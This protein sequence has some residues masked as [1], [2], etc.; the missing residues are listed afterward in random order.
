MVGG[1]G[2]GDCRVGTVVIRVT[3]AYPNHFQDFGCELCL[4][5]YIFGWPTD[6]ESACD[7]TAPLGRFLPHI[8]EV[9]LVCQSKDN[10]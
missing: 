5:Y 1:H 9:T 4:C 3:V 6:H 8:A 7:P 2:R 10:V